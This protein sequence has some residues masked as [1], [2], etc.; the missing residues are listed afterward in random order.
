MNSCRVSIIVPTY[1]EAENLP[2]LVPQIAQAFHARGWIWEMI[3][4]DD[5]SPDSTPQVLENLVRQWPQ[6]RYL[7]RKEERGLSSA[8]LAGFALARHEYLL[9]MD[10]DLSHPPEAAPGLIDPL[11]A[12]TADF[13]IGSRYVAGGRT[14]EWSVFRRLNSTLATLL[15]RPFCGGVKDPMAGFFALS[16]QTWRN[17][18]KLNPVGYKI[19]LELMV[20][21]R[22]SRVVETPIVFRN[23]THGT[24]KLTLREQFL[25]LEHLRRLVDYQFPRAAMFSRVLFVSACVGGG[26]AAIFMLLQ[27]VLRFPL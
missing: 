1:G 13:V 21:C 3:V 17:A 6:L 26:G 16:R 22:V 10:A 20:K 4:V 5:N 23:R 7:I 12:G 24:S 14:E 27:P 11:L 8:V 2:R 25:Y 9:V 15:C 19:G 18:G